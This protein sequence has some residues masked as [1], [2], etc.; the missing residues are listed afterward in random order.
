MLEVAERIDPD[1]GH[2]L[3]V[4]ATEGLHD[5]VERYRPPHPRR[6]SRRPGG[7]SP[8]PPAEPEG[9]VEPGPTRDIQRYVIK[10]QAALS[11]AVE[12]FHRAAAKP[13]CEG[14]HEEM[15]AARLR[16][17]PPHEDLA[18]GM[19][20]MAFTAQQPLPRGNMTELARA[21]S[22]EAQRLAASEDREGLKR[23]VESLENMLPKLAEDSHTLLDVL[24]TRAF[25]MSVGEQVLDACERL[26][27]D[28]EASRLEP[29]VERLQASS[30]RDDS[31]ACP[32]CAADRWEVFRHAGML[33]R[34]TLPVLGTAGGRVAPPTKEDLEPGRLAE[35]AGMD[36][37]LSV[38]VALVFLLSAL[39]VAVARW[40]R[41]RGLRL[42][43]ERL[44]HLVDRRDW[45]W[46]GLLGVV[47]PLL[48]FVCMARLNPWNGR[49]FG[50]KMV[51]H[52]V[53]LIQ[54]GN[55]PVLVWLASVQAVRWR[56]RR[57]AGGLG[58]G[59]KRLWPGWL[60]AA[61]CLVGMAA[62]GAV[63]Y[64]PDPREWMFWVASAGGL[65]ALL[66][67]ISIALGA[68]FS[69]R[70]RAV[71]RGTAALVLVPVLVFAGLVLALFPPFLE[72]EERYWVAR[73]HL[74]RTDAGSPGMH[75]HEGKIIG[76][77]REQL[78]EVLESPR[79]R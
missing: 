19:L 42:I 45:L 54:A 38:V 41:R 28:E 17:L 3:L 16:L 30:L 56:L 11:E 69:S 67:L 43:S 58:F 10:D 60:V 50:A 78:I 9:L 2:F 71:E 14:Y 1:N 77:L 6:R 64:L 33:S 72:H 55:L 32:T 31:S 53:I 37:G 29:L 49:E 63:L 44:E 46:I 12:L 27:M 13:R 22:A 35:F 8:P 68:V 23:L 21:L 5:A 18:S 62:P 79:G 36:Q 20:R 52:L 24:I 48:A 15:L 76:A 47:L 4:K 59:P 57:R 25:G 7:K 70:Q 26:G 34:L 66:V 73:D 39:V 65:L 61:L 74:M 40:L 51:A 75:S